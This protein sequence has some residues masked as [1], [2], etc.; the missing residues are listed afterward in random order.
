MKFTPWLA[1]GFFAA[2]SLAAGADADWREYLGGPERSHYSALAQITPANVAQL[3]VAWEYHT[4]DPGE[5]QCNP[6]I[7]AGVL[8]AVTAAGDVFALEAATGREVWR[9]SE[10]GEPPANRTL[11]GNRILR[12]LTYWADGADQRILFTAGPWLCALDATTGRRI[13]SFGD[14]GKTSLKQGLGESAK[15]KYVVSTTPGALFGDLLIMPL[16]VSEAAD[17]APGSVQAFNVRTGALAWTFRTIPHPGEFGYE[18]WPKETWRNTEV[19]GANCWAG[20]AIDRVRGIVFVPTGSAAPDFWGGAR[21]GANL[22][23]NC[24]VALD[25]RTGKRLWHF[26]FFHHDI[27]DRDLPAPPNLVTLTRE[28][29]KIDAVAQITKSGRV[30]VFDRET[31][32]PLFPI[33]E[34]AA[35]KSTLPGEEAWPT[36]P[37]PV[38]PAAFS[39]QTLTEAD[40]SPYAENRDALLAKFRGARTGAFQPFGVQDTIFFPGYDGGGEWGGAAVDPDGVLYVNANEMAWIAR[41]RETPLPVELAAL[42]PGQRAYATLCLACHGPERKGNPAGNVPAMVDLAARRTREEV[43]QLITSGKGMMPGFPGLGAA[44]KQAL[45]EFLFGTEKIEGAAAAAMPATPPLPHTPY[46]F[47]GYV[48]F[49][50]SKGFPAISPPWGSLTAIDLNTGEHR[51]QVV[52]GEFKELTAKGIPP[53]GAE[54]YGGPV[55]TAGGLLFIAGTKDG[56][57]RAFDRKTGRLLWETELPAPGFATPSTYAAGGKQ[58]VVVAAGGTK[59]GTKKGDSYIAYALPGVMNSAPENRVEIR[60]PASALSWHGRLA[61]VWGPGTRNTGETPVPPQARN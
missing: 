41:L 45:V 52:L 24:L 55:V 44:D 31:G 54:N 15:D 6:I 33:E 49:L 27:W 2:A 13:A 16:R 50:D 26:Q 3:R 28:G 59:L 58:F 9:Y 17:A 56:R 42:A 46:R 39:R 35:P 20:M 47:E 30:F 57:L 19:G 60:E 40:L 18:T 22:F 53:T 61:R 10:R 23:A 29:R 5:V 25:A 7:V 12:G 48:R 36:Q 51:W 21:V 11:S 8:Y 34:V 38:K 14:G 37:A 4:G 43:A 32:A 1:P